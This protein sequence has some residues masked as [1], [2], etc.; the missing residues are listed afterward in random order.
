MKPIL[1][2][3]LAGF[4]VLA[5]LSHTNAQSSTTT[6]ILVRHAEKDTSKAGSTMMQSDPELS[7]EGKKRAEKLITALKDY[8]ADAVYSTNFI[9]T[10]STVLP[11]ATERHMDIQVYDARNLKGFA[12]ELKALKGKTVVVAGHSN[13]IPLLA[14]LLIGQNKYQP[15]DESVYNK[16]FIVRVTDGVPT[17]EIIEY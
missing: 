8:K 1:Y 4:F 17:C 10:K 2:T 11:F 12:E 14:N 9:R 7:P 3:L 5:G 15:L 16:I 13:T 6:Y